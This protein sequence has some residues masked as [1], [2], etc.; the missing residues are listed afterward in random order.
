MLANDSP[1]ATSPRPRAR[2]TAAIAHAPLTDDE[3]AWAAGVGRRLRAEFAALVAA[4][5]VHERTAA[6]LERVLGTTRAVAH[7]LLAALATADDLEVLTRLPGVEGLRKTADAARRRLGRPVK[8]ILAGCDS[9]LAEFEQ[10]IR[11]TGG[12][13]AKLI[14]RLRAAPAIDVAAVPDDAAPPGRREPVRR[15]MHAV[16]KS[17][18]GRSV[19]TRTTISIVR[20]R[21]DNPREAEYVHTRA[22]IGYRAAQ[23]AQPLVI[24]SWITS[25]DESRKMDVQYRDL[26]GAAIEGREVSGLIEPF[27]TSPLPLVASRDTSGRLIQIID[28]SGVRP[29]APINAVMSYRLPSVG[30]VPALLDPPIF[31]EAV[32]VTSPT[33]NLVADFYFHRSMLAGCTPALNLYLGRGTGGCDLLDRWHEQ[34]SGAPV[35]GLLGPGLGSAHAS[36][37]PR[38]A[39]L[40]RHVFDALAWD[41]SEFVGFRCEERWPLWQCDYVISLDYRAVPADSPAARMSLSTKKNTRP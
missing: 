18:C 41:P 31:L 10:L 22:F 1:A 13:H 25:E 3:R 37:W 39:E 35:L 17:L 15:A 6:G 29:D 27:C 19:D 11:R 28:R 7:R 24:S 20:P 21:P 34:I 23:G 8:S 30:P 26:A 16:I 33:E 38:H 5:P 9:A 32:N 40:T 2:P 12:S 36:A 4:L 14:A